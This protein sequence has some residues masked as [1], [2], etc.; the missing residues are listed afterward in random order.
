MLNIEKIQ[1][2]GDRVLITPDERVSYTI[3]ES[4]YDAEANKDRD[5]LVEEAIMKDVER[6]VYCDYQTG[7][8]LALGNTKQDSIKVG[9][10]V[11]FPIKDTTKFDLLENTE[12]INYWAITS[13]VIE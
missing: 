5:T 10:R 11:V 8:I 12:I 3:T 7:V 9:D 13:K 4:V 1:L 6:T 2:Q